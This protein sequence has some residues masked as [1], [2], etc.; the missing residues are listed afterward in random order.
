MGDVNTDT[1]LPELDRT[2]Y[3][4]NRRVGRLFLPRYLAGE[5]QQLIRHAK[6]E[7]YEALQK[8]VD[9]YSSGKLQKRK[10]TSLE[11]EF[12]TEIFG[13]ALG[14]ALFS[15]GK[16]EWHIEAKFNVNGGEADAAIGQFNTTSPKVPRVLI[17]LKG[18]TVNVDRDRFNGRTAVQQCWDYLNAVPQCPWGI[19]CNYVSF[20]LYHRNHTPRVYE[21]FTLPNLQKREEF[22]QFYYLFHRDGFLPS[23]EYPTPRADALLEKTGERK[24]EVGNVLYEEYHRNRVA[25]I[26]HLSE[27]PRSMPLDQAIRVAQKLLDRIVFIAFCE[28][29]GL[30][31]EKTLF[32]AYKQLPAYY[33]TPNPRWQN[34]LNLFRS[35]DEG[36]SEFGISG[37]DGGLFRMDAAVDSLDLEDAWTDFFKNIASYDFRDEVSVDVLGHLFE[38]SITDVERIRLGGLFGTEIEE[39][40]EPRMKKSA[41][42]KRHGIYYTPP[43]L[44]ALI[45]EQT[46]GAVVSERIQD[47]VSKHGLEW[48]TLAEAEREP[49]ITCCQEALGKLRQIKVVDPACGSGAFLIRAYDVFEEKYLDIADHFAYHS[50]DK[51]RGLRDQIPE[52]I[53]QNNLFGVDLSPEAV[54]ITQLSLWIRSA[55]K[56]KTLE[57]LSEHIVC[58][59]SLVEDQDVHPSAMIWKETFADVFSRKANGFDCVIGNPP[60]ERLKL[61]EREFFSSADPDIASAV[62]A[63]ERRRLIQQLKKE[64]PDLYD[65]YLHAKEEAE[66]TLDYARN[67]QRFPLTGRGDI[68]TYSLF[69]EL[70]LQITGNS[71]RVGLLVPSGIATDHTTRAF[72][73][74]LVDSQSLVGLYD[75]ENR[76]RLFP[77]VHGAYKFCVLLFGGRDIEHRSADFVFFAH[78]VEDLRDKKRHISLSPEDFKRLNPNTMTC[79]IFRTSRDAELTK[80]IYRRIP[81]LVDESREEGGNPWAIRFFTMFHQTNDAEL[82]YTAEQ[83]MEADFSR[84]G[85]YWIKQEGKQKQVFLPLY[86]A[87]M[88]QA[89]DHRAAGVAI[90]KEN[91]FRQGQTEPTSL[92][93]HQNPEFAVIPRWWVQSTKVEDALNQELPPAYLAFKNVTSPTNTRTMIAAFIPCVAVSNSAP[94]IFT[95]SEVSVRKQACLLANLNSFVLD[96]VTRQKIGNVNLNFYLVRQFP[97]FPPDFYDSPCPWDKTEKLVDWVSNRALR[98]SCTSDDMKPLAEASGLRPLVHRWKADD[99]AELQAELDAAYFLLYGIA[100]SEVEY[101]LSTFAGTQDRQDGLLDGLSVTERILKHVRAL[102]QKTNHS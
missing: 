74:T 2:L 89:Y 19:V 76:K 93:E 96:Y 60:W 6:V 34:F 84:D 32:K 80:A 33:K 61:Q 17:E 81:V 3:G 88:I 44:T 9:L 48:K 56:G 82:F 7:A 90:D 10:E 100:D 12:L 57:D 69:A 92:V 66:R 86:E 72:F 23:R 64:N 99:R 14:Y 87:K 102:H 94:L 98:L 49:A 26:K 83:L 25:L 101:V 52:F 53:L 95:S 38:K 78:Q 29:R 35:I 42:R 16:D 58:G 27:K 18:P 40:P 91:W 75:F 65:R 36:N 59:N 70:A 47:T 51:A 8:W 28:N 5:S 68:N 24:S 71:G 43:G 46:V 30:L 37:Y 4:E 54:E 97:M 21:L 73:N 31:P 63:A 85:P 1:L 62:S 22:D 55:V 79:P 13:K 77:D 67:S 11:G 39:E 50:T 20:R 45:V 15:D 41:Q